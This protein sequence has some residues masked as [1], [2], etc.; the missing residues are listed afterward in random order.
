[1]LP[2]SRLSW[3][4]D[5]QALGEAKNNTIAISARNQRRSV[6]AN[7]AGRER[8]RRGMRPALLALEDR[9]LLSTFT[10]TSAAD[11]APA[12]SPDI[13][14]LRWAVEQAN[15][16]ATASSIEIELGTS[17]ATITLMQGQLE[18]DNT[19]A[20]TTIYDG[21]GEGAVTISGNNASRV[22]QVDPSVNASITGMTITG[23]N[24][25]IGGGLFSEG[26]TTLT[27]CT[28]SG[29]YAQYGGGGVYTG[30][31]YAKGATTTLTNCTISGNSSNGF[32]GGG[33]VTNYG[34][35]TLTNCTVSGNSAEGGGGVRNL[36]GTT[37]TL[38]NTI[39]AG[40]TARFG[41]DAFGVFTSEGNNL[42]GQTDRSSGWVASDL[43]GTS[44]DPLN[45][46]LAALS[47]YGGTTQTMALLPGSPAINAGASG[48]DIPATDQ[49]GLGRVGVVDIGA[50]ESQGFMLTVVP[51]STPQTATIGTA[52]ANPLAVNL[53]ANNAIEPV[54]GGLVS[55]VA[56]PGSNG[57]TA[58]SLPPFAVIANG[59]AA[60]TAVPN[61]VDGSYEV[62]A[63]VSGLSA[64]FSLT[65]AGPVYPS[66][67][68]NTTSDSLAPGAGLLSLREAIGFADTAPSGDSNITF[69]NQVFS[70]PLTITLTG[71]QLELS[72]M[73][74]IVTITGPNQGVT[75]SGGG[76]SR[77]FQVDKGVT[78]S[79]SGVT[80]TG[81]NAGTGGG[82]NNEGS[83]TLTNCVVSGNSATRGGGLYNLGMATLA[84]CTVS[85]NYAGIDGGGLL[86]ASDASTILTNCSVSGNT[87]SQDG[88]GATNY[89]SLGLTNCSVSGNF[90]YEGG[91]VSNY[92]AL[93]LSNCV[94]NDNTA[95]S[96]VFGGGGVRNN[97]DATATLK[98]CIL[99]RN[100]ASYGGA[101]YNWSYGRSTL[102][103]CTKTSPLA[104]AR[105]DSTAAA[106]SITG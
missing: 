103:N 44:A 71:T 100:S 25:G 55:F 37:M 59:Q 83:T 57:A 90:A 45:P 29:N 73:A 32:P 63:S 5:N 48:A 76:S 14:T 92:G 96:I 105:T 31:Y 66:L 28:V 89:G 99:S 34:T 47:D 16:A 93:A 78:A 7:V 72:A 69:D 98:N 12:G 43:T 60:V 27:G 75:V 67:V 79:I 106:A 82:V 81:G 62:V 35:T 52:F 85:D 95:T 22:F 70:T 94:V 84:N 24:A 42:V 64:P 15:A 68:V 3:H 74:G 87:A 61:N 51:G 80:I 19:A 11:S 104:P 17:P 30:G 1:M 2:R 101:L 50:F 33:G 88:G 97:S 40:N 65:N 13:N 39:V 54:D 36:Y 23:G 91:G 26:M 4:E 20:A 21:P 46:V 9:R 18:L 77:V 58:I 49:R 86:T 10:V 56:L 8:K 102:S 41:P 6:L 38:V 53:T